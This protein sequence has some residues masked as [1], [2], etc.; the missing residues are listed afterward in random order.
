M[1]R[2]MVDVE[3]SAYLQRVGALGNA[4]M[5]SMQEGLARLGEE[6][7]ALPTLAEAEFSVVSDPAS[8]GEKSLSG[9]WRDTHGHQV[10]SIVFHTDGSVYAEYNVALPH[11]VKHGWFVDMITVWGRDGEIK[12]EPQL[13]AVL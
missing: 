13:L 3:V 8:G 5:V 1:K 9:T 12:S 7:F 4:V 6:D 11:P 10:G 2:L